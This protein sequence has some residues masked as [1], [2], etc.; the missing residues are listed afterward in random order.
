MKRYFVLLTLLLTIGCA[1]RNWTPLMN[2]ELVSMTE[3]EF[4][5][6]KYKK[7][8][9]ITEEYC[10]SND[11]DEEN[12]LTYKKGEADVGLVDELIMRAQKKN[13]ADGFIDVSID[14]D[15]EC[16]RLSAVAIKKT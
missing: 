2:A 5:K 7:L 12:L 6:S 14:K 10:F 11:D 15:A 16:V 3:S 1:S 9:E 4:E 8:D 13:N